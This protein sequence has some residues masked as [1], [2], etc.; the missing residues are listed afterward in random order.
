MDNAD[1]AILEIGTVLLEKY[2]I[3]NLLITRSEKGMTLITPEGHRNFAAE[4][5]EVFDVSG[6]GDTVIATVA[7]GLAAGAS[8]EDAVALANRAAGIAVGHFGT[9][10]IDSASLAK[11]SAGKVVEIKD[12]GALAEG[13]RARG[14][15]IVF[16]NGC[17]DIIHR[18]HVSYLKRT[19]DLGDKL[20]VGLNSD[21]SVR[22]LKGEGR[23]V[24]DQDSRAEVLAAL[25]AVDHV[26]VFDD[27][28]PYELIK[29][30][31][32]DILTKGGDYTPETVVGSEFAGE[33]VIIPL[34]EGHSTTSIIER[35]PGNG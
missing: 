25:E 28:T 2:G 13:L 19:A 34:V 7:H 33:T 11:G 30:I 14:E 29:S 4:A 22:R 32:P 35:S 27:D 21:A 16:T 15:R 3:Q 9:W 12:V 1:S 23:P 20:I 8:L 6:A 10:P 18:G 17:F 24:N 5:R 31:R 26:V